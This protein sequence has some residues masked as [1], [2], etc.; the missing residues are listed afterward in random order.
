MKPSHITTPRQLSECTFTV[1]DPQ[2]A[3]TEKLQREFNWSTYIVLLIAL[4]SV[5]CYYGGVF[6]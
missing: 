4:I 1:G 5:A 6:K 3:R 2:V